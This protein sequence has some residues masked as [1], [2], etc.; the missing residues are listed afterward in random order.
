MTWTQFMDMHSGGTTKVKDF[1]YIYI[2]ASE[3]EARS[4][5]TEK[6]S[7]D[8]DSVGCSCCG[9]NFSVTESETLEQSTAYQRNCRYDSILKKWVEEKGDYGEYQ[10]LE[11]Y[12]KKTTVLII[13]KDKT[14]QQ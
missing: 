10:T 11:E 8:P 3:Q 12:C 13:P 2:E 1:E 6:F 14:P 7:E 5:F 4:I 9:E